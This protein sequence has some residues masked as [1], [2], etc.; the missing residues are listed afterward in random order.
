MKSFDCL[1]GYHQLCSWGS[2]VCECH[3]TP[4]YASYADE[5]F[6]HPYTTDDEIM[7]IGVP[8]GVVHKYYFAG[9]RNI[10]MCGARDNKRMVLFDGLPNQVTCQR[11]LRMERPV[12]TG[13]R[14]TPLTRP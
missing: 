3:T 9:A 13:I 14:S 12:R 2:C 4:G 11:C 6:D 5:L 7:L 8:G 10:T 1:D